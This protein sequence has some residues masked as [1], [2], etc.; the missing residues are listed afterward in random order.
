MQS[1]RLVNSKTEHKQI[2][3]YMKIETTSPSVHLTIRVGLTI[4]TF[5]RSKLFICLYIAKEF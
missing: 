2:E 1:P 3:W 4:N 5:E